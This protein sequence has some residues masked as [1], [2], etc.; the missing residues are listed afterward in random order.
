[1]SALARLDADELT[2]WNG[3]GLLIDDV[4]GVLM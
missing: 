1:M 3:Y 4:V 2:V